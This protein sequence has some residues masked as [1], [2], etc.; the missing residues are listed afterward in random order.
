MSE[1]WQHGKRDR[2]EELVRRFAEKQGRVVVVGIG[3]V[4]LPLVAEFAR[5]GFRVTGLD[6]D[7]RKVELLNQGESYIRDVPSSDLA[8]HVRAGR[9]DATANPGVLREADAVVVC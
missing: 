7:T 6:Y 1:R 3:Y 5:E 2:V 4:G 8:S 9:L